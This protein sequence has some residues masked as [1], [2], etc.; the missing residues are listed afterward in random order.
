MYNNK[1]GLGRPSRENEEERSKTSHGKKPNFRHT[2]PENTSSPGQESIRNS[3]GKK[4]WGRIRQKLKKGNRLI[5]GE[6]SKGNGEKKKTRR[7]V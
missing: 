7:K 6:L 2:L 1:E 5:K 4:E 3:G